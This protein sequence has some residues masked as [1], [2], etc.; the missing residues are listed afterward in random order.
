MK[1]ITYFDD[2]G[3]RLNRIFLHHPGSASLEW[4]ELKT[5]DPYLSKITITVDMLSSLCELRDM[6]GKPISINELEEV[7]GDVV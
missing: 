7:L 1:E 3:E 2:I 4:E 6:D 5:H